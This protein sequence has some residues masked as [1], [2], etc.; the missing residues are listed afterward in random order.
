MLMDMNVI[1]KAMKSSTS[2]KDGVGI[3]DIAIDENGHLLFQLTNGKVIDAGRL[4]E[5]RPGEDGEST[6]KV[7]ISGGL[8]FVP[9]KIKIVSASYSVL[10]SDHTVECTGTTAFTLTMP[11]SSITK[12]KE[13]NLK[14]KTNKPI[15]V[16]ATLGIDGDTSIDIIPGVTGSFP[17][18]HLKYDGTGFIIV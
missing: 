15:T 18:M 6:K 7:I 10:T 17:N 3:H 12:G 9:D 14:N 5:G 16:N 13:F 2:G 4:P 8:N 1:E 11:G